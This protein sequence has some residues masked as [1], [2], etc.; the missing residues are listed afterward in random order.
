MR[1]LDKEEMQLKRTK[2]ESLSNLPSG[3]PLNS[4]G[5]QDDV[6][7]SE[8]IKRRKQEKEINNINLPGMKLQGSNVFGTQGLRS[9]GQGGANTNTNTN[10]NRPEGGYMARGRMSSGMAA[11]EA[12]RQAFDG[13]DIGQGQA[14][15]AMNMNNPNSNSN[16]AYASLPKLEL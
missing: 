16:P 2:W 3:H 5:N 13:G 4:G 10:N 8:E 7:M 9:Q 12:D 14:M 6:E 1:D 15:P 11:V